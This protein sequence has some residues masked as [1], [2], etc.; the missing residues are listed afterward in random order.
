MRSAGRRARTARVVRRRD[1]PGTSSGCA[2]AL[3]RQEPEIVFRIRAGNRVHRTV[4]HRERCRVASRYGLAERSSLQR[5]HRSM[6]SGRGHRRPSPAGGSRKNNRASVGRPNR[7][8]RLPGPNVNLVGTPRFRSWSQRSEL[9]CETLTVT[10]TCDA[11]GESASDSIACESIFV[12]ICLPVVR[13][14]QASIWPCNVVVLR[15]TSTPVSDAANAPKFA[16]APRS[17]VLGD[18][19]G[20][21]QRSECPGIERQRHESRLSCEQQRTSPRAGRRAV[22]STAWDASDRRR[23]G[24]AP[25]NDPT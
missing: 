25:S 23:V 19:H 24:A 16:N 1:R 10:A 3:Q 7:I 14:I 6:A 15:Y 4:F 17:Q 8:R 13:S 21:A 2:L 9:F 5:P 22:R 12:A 18:C 20:S 11:S